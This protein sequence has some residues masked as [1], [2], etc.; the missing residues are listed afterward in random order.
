MHRPQ[1]HPLR[2]ATDDHPVDPAGQNR[3]T[4][5]KRVRFFGEHQHRRAVIDPGGIP[6]GDAATI[7]ERRLQSRQLIERRIGPR[8]LIRGEPNDRDD[9]VFEPA[10]SGRQTLQPLAPQ[11]ITVLRIA[12]D[13]E[14][15]R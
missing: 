3:P 8:V 9:L 11:G 6:R 10:R 13:P 2:F 4:A 12:T 7:E 1:P 15:G 5:G 14:L